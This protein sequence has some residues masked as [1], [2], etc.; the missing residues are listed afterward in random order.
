MAVCLCIAWFAFDPGF[1]PIVTAILLAAGFLVPLDAAP[2]Q[3]RPPAPS[4][5]AGPP[6]QPV[7]TVPLVTTDLRPEVGGRPSAITVHRGDL[8]VLTG[9]QGI[10]V[11]E[12]KP[13]KGSRAK[14][15][16]RFAPQLRGPE[17]SGSGDVFEQYARAERNAS[18]VTDVGGDLLI[19]AGPYR[20]EWS[21]GGPA[22]GYV[23]PHEGGYSAYVAPDKSLAAF[24]L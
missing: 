19:K 12:I 13:L 9:A 1:E 10:A 22:H 7:P 6:Q 8:L 14:Y 5:S 11:V 16:W 23:Y 24:R 21:Q 20:I 18:V 17:E 4:E 3:D 15:R 2:K